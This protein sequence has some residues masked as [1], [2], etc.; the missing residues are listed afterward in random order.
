MSHPIINGLATYGIIRTYMLGKPLVAF[1]LTIV[2]VAGPLWFI[3]G[4][5]IV[6]LLMFKYAFL[7]GAGVLA[8]FLLFKIAKIQDVALK[9]TLAIGYTLSVLFFTLIAVSATREHNTYKLPPELKG[10]VSSYWTKNNVVCAKTK[11]GESGIVR[12][13]N[14]DTDFVVFSA[15]CI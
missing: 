4:L 13:T 10:V 1:L 6:I 14:I 5:A 7:V 9:I 11:D 8:V 2:F 15:L 3:G 12:G